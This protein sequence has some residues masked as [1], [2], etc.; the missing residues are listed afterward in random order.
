MKTL[1]L[2]PSTPLVRVTYKRDGTLYGAIIP[3]PQS[4]DGLCVALLKRK[5]GMGQ[6]ERVMPVFT[7]RHT[8]D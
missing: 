6:V 1:F 2:I 8:R 7:I 3:N 5:V 4:N